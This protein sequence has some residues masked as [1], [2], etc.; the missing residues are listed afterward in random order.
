MP[1]AGFEDFAACVLHMKGQGH[2]EEEARRICGRLQADAEGEKTVKQGATKK[3]ADGEHPAS[4]YLV[5][6]DPEKP[7]TWHLRVRDIN[8]K[9]DHGL[10][11][12]AHAALVSPEG[13]RGQPYEGP[14][15]EEAIAKLKAMYE[16]EKMAWPESGKQ[17]FLA[18]REQ[19]IIRQAA[20]PEGWVWE[21]ELVRV[22]ISKTRL[23][24]TRQVLEAALPL[25]SGVPSYADHDWQ[26]SIRDLIGSIERPRMTP[27]AA[28]AELHL[29]KSEEAIRQ[30]LQAITKAR[31]GLAGMSID[32]L[33]E[34]EPE[35]SN[36]EPNGYIAES[37]GKEQTYRV[38]KIHKVASFDLV[39]PPAAGGKI[40]RAVASVGDWLKE[41]CPTAELD[42]TARTA[43]TTL[44]GGKMKEKIEII[45]QAI[46]R[47]DPAKAAG[48]EAEIKDLEESEQLEKVT[49]ALATLEPPKVQEAEGG[50]QKAEEKPALSEADKN[51]LERATASIEQAELTRCEAV[52][53]KALA[54]SNLPV[55]L[56]EEVARRYKGK[57]FKAEE[58][59]E[60]IKQIRQTFARVVPEN[61]MAS[62]TVRI[63]M[64][65]EDKLQIALDRLFGL[66]HELKIETDARGVEK[67][68]K[69][70]PLP[71]VP[72]FR[73]LRQAYTAYT[74]DPDVLGETKLSRITQIFNTAGFPYALASTLNRL[75]LRDYAAAN[76]RQMELV[77][78]VTA[79]SDFRNQERIRVGYFGDLSTVGEDENYE[80][81][82]AVTDEKIS[83]AVATRGNLL[84]VTRRTI[85]NDDLGFVAAQ[86]AKLGRSAARTLAKYIWGFALDVTTYDADGL[87]WFHATHG[88]LGT[89]ALS[90]VIATSV[91]LMN[92]V[93]LAFFN[94]AEKDSGEKL[95][96]SGPYLLVVP[97]AIHAIAIAFN[98]AEYQDASFTPN[99]W[100]HAF[101]ADNEQIFANPLFGTE[102]NDWMVF[103]ISRNV[104]ILEIGFLQGRQNPEFFLADQPTAEAMFSNDRMRY[105]VRHEYAGDILD[106]RGGYKAVVA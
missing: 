71:D 72:P 106:Y 58:L 8:G 37:N 7:D 40:L 2:G 76:Y 19:G 18:V 45:L 81:I 73:G 38:K 99:P 30:K 60:D 77:S 98:Q 83:Y 43:S 20:G 85:I 54:G 86:V 12:D 88:N 70:N 34:L 61:R 62:P 14:G 46:K 80:E 68:V 66:S 104:D 16:A 48:L 9:P 95:G 74:G 87:N 42:S 11:G 33:V 57:P 92:I 39:S 28:V 65:E 31:E 3:E 105:K 63:T 22:G 52:L 17:Q 50:K 26:H 90:A 4:H 82:P 32:C 5:V 27:T 89:T 10:M 24:W 103:D 91:G 25:F 29:L 36:N 93:D 1:F 97:K 51:L 79:P 13:F 21:V 94:M 75:L 23:N 59:E 6:V 41:F 78:R 69:G 55:P 101:G 84:T 35:K 67:I 64:Q 49:Q 102:L 100:Y 56:A 47:F 15:K 53:Q 44:L 96:L